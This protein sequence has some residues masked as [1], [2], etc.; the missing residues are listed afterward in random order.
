MQWKV[1]ERHEGTVEVYYEGAQKI[2]SGC[3]KDVEVRSTSD[4][5]ELVELTRL[6]NTHTKKS[7]I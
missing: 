6:S 2:S 4:E 5:A 1:D 7:Y 3:A